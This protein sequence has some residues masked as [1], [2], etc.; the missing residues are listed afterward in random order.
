MLQKLFKFHGGL[1]L[2]S[3]KTLSSGTPIQRV[4]ITAG[5][6]LVIPLAQSAGA[7][8]NPIVSV[9]DQ[10]RKGQK[11]GSV[12]SWLSSAVH[13]STSGRVTAIEPRPA[14]HPSGLTSLAIEIEADGEDQWINRVPVDY[15][16]LSP[17][18]NRLALQEAGVAGLGGAV[19]PSHA[20]LPESP[21][22]TLVINGAECEPYITCDDRLMRERADEVVAGISILRD[23]LDARKV[24]IAIEDNKPEALAAVRAANAAAN[25]GF[26]VVAVPTLYPTGDVRQLTRILTGISVPTGRY[27]S[28]F[29]VQCFN[30]AT[31]CSIARVF[32]RG[33][34]L[35]SRIVTL[36]GQ[37]GNPGNWEAPIGMPI[38]QLLALAGL[39]DAPEG[40]IMGGPMMGFDLP[41]LE[42]PVVKACN[43]LIVR[44]PNTFTR[45]P[46]MPCIRCGA[47]A[48]ACPQ[49]LQPFE[50]YWWSRAR[51]FERVERYRIANCI[52]C[53]CCAYVCPA[54][55]PLARYFR[56][57][58]GEIRAQKQEQKMAEAA[59]E[60]FEFKQFREAREKSEKAERLAKA[61]A[62]QVAKRKAEETASVETASHACPAEKTGQ[63]ETVKATTALK[64]AQKN[65][66]KTSAPE[67][68]AV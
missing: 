34:P 66:H 39:E 33:E 32:L 49:K 23:L 62:A 41:T 36:T 26:Q 58:K 29:G 51:Q 6:R 60:R 53:G 19:F 8:A 3:Y 44:A 64:P 28:D 52:E 54:N 45:G 13:A 1:H 27:S 12:E 24:L 11:I 14:P 20:K 55:I 59:L 16:N 25:A 40:V 57:A 56:F 67:E 46:E 21:T 50:L 48:R 15:R 47:C 30:V 43:C 5:Q 61:A 37:V 9:G 2:P 4:A 68:D 22:H 35:V 65:D 10:V 42:A 18:E 63:E 31:A 7:P 38:A 17:E